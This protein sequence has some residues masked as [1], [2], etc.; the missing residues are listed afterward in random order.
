MK[1]FD[2]YNS[3]TLAGSG[4]QFYFM[5]EGD[6]AYIGRIYYKVYA[7]GKYTYS[8]LFSN[9]MDSTYF[10]GTVSHCNLLCDEWEILRASI[11]V[12]DECSETVAGEVKQFYPLTFRGKPH[13]TVM[14]GEFFTTDGVELEAEKDSYLCLEIE[15]C[16]S[17]IPC[18]EESILP[19]FVKEDGKWLPSNYV[20]CPGMIGCN[21]EVK[22]RI[23]FLGDSITQGIGTAVNSY[24]HWN[25]RLA[26]AIGP[27]YSYW[28][29][30][31]GFGR[32]SDAASDGAWLFKAKQMDK[33]IVCFG[34]NDVCQGR[35]EEQIKQ[36][37]LTIVLQLKKA[38]VK[39]MV[40]TLPPFDL[41]EDALEKW[42]HINEYIRHE[43]VTEADA[44]F[45]VV[46]VLINGN[47]TEG[48]AKYN[49]HPNEEGCKAWAEELLPIIKDFLSAGWL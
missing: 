33:V 6:K 20:P 32:A 12:C 38:G 14:P 2:T 43:L 10:D 3:N 26:D 36:D 16:G 21:R 27:D 8:L 4:N 44:V 41:Q 23:G 30:G 9:I 39:V 25:A 5:P 48:K 42:L 7:G 22:A 13:K 24:L 45:D 37:L 35:M 40:Q 47:E 49:G 18:H 28:N 17:R 31:L 11:G 29:L 46:P 34:V 1:W 19:V 15:F